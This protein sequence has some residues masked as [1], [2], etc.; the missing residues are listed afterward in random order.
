M[1]MRLMPT[2]QNHLKDWVKGLVILYSVL[3]GI[4]ILATIFIAVSVDQGHP[5]FEGMEFV[6]QIFLVVAGITFFKPNLKLA[7]ANG[8][9][10]RTEFVVTMLAALT[11]GAVCMVLNDGVNLL[12]GTVYPTESAFYMTYSGFNFANQAAYYLTK[13][14]YDI[15]G[16]FFCFVVGYFIGALYY[17]MNRALKI[18]VSI[19][20]P[21]L[22][23]SAAGIAG[24]L[25]FRSEF[26]RD[27]FAWAFETIARIYANPYS[28]LLATILVH[29]L[30]IFFS[31]L[32]IRTAPIKEQG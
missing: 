25:S 19:G 2:Y 31:Y 23:S 11:V 9:S 20:V 3:V 10:R 29:A 15:L 16:N 27:L 22:F 14:A 32:L 12:Y 5:S 1:N 24:F 4:F 6:S 13:V 30:L 7:L 18:A 17:R 21:V 28:Y 8:I 26:W